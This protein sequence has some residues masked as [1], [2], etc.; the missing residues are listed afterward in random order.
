MRSDLLNEASN[1]PTKPTSKAPA[2]ARNRSGRFALC[3]ENVRSAAA[4]QAG[5]ERMDCMNRIILRVNL[6]LMV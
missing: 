4:D 1:I 2:P 6:K 5:E 3:V